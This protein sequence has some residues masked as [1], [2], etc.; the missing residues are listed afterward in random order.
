MSER[1]AR[2]VVVRTWRERETT[3][4]ASFDTLFD[5]AAYVAYARADGDAPDYAYRVFDIE[6]LDMGDMLTR[7]ECAGIVA[8]AIVE[9]CRRFDEA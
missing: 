6:H 5:A 8:M 7:E 3:V 2:H 9:G 4:H 1:Y